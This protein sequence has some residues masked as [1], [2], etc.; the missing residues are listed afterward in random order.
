MKISLS[1][2]V[3]L[4]T[5]VT[6]GIGVLFVSFLSYT[7]I[8]E[9]FKHNILNSLVAELSDNAQSIQRNITDVKKDVTLLLNNEN[10][11]AIERASHNRY[12][13]DE[14]SNE[15]LASLKK[16]LGTSFK[17]ILGHTDAYFNIRL[18]GV[19]GK[20]LVVARKDSQGNV[21]IEKEEQLQNKSHRGYFQDSIHLQ[22][23][24]YYISKINYNREH[25]RFSRPYIPTIRIAK[26]V[27]I[28]GKLFAILIINSN[29]Y[30][31]FA[32][33]KDHQNVDK[34]IYLANQEGY[35]LYNPDKTKVFGFELN[36]NYKIQDD[37]D[38]SKKMYFQNNVAFAQKKLFIA[39]KRYLTVALSTTDKFLKEQSSEY[40]RSLSVYI[41]MATLIIA[42]VT[43]LLVRYL[44]TPIV[45][46]TKKAQ[47]IS[48]GGNDAIIDFEGIRTNDE[49][50]EL[51]RSLKL[52]IDKIENSKKEIEK[53]VQQR[54]SE[55]NALNE[56]LEQIV[57]EKTGEN[58]K[59]LELMQQQTKMASMGEMIGA[60][61]HQWRQPLNE[62]GISI[63]N[64]KYDYE[65]GLVDAEFIDK[66]I[67]KNKEI[68]KFMSNTIDDFRNFYRVDKT[69]E[70]FDVK[71]AIT[72]TISLQM[73]QL[74][75]NNIHI[76][77][78][79]ETFEVNGFKNEFQQVVLNII[80]NA[81]DALLTNDIVN[82][83]IFINIQ[84]GTI[85]IRDNGGGIEESV[86]ERIFEPYFTTKE[87]GKGTGM[88]LYMSKMI[89]EDNMAAKLSAYN[90]NDGVE[91]R[92]EF[93]EE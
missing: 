25:G 8:S 49:I 1:T 38:L 52:M 92:M 51:S 45:D 84:S 54:T 7:Q 18:I 90:T 3:A 87:Q 76:F 17:S 26:A 67:A 59:Q 10:I 61:A 46:L 19:N 64:L 55:L 89:I 80:N 82:P 5:F 93:N 33:L 31:L 53:K 58:I 70:L 35:Y 63:Q 32:P 91:F 75:N 72:K 81:K 83:K 56:N 6:A 86:L 41:L 79:G 47:E 29:I 50:G 62:I 22:K 16:K 60:I 73:A 39:D 15:T 48:S 66:F 69:K 36:H 13:Y 42:L 30:K 68:I 12:H 34:K 4:G 14:Q 27:Y 23:G 57:E 44:I 74:I 11:Y 37:F 85:T 78:E 24:N 77:I 20:E 71:E 9:Y 21:K 65:D 40:K 2:K 88:G 43:M 28:N